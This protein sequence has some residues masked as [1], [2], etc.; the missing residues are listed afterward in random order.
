MTREQLNREREASA[1][2]RA[3]EEAKARAEHRPP[4]HARVVFS[5]RSTKR[6]EAMGF[7]VGDRP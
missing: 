3:E 4:A 1:K 6:W 7:V 5:E 2:R